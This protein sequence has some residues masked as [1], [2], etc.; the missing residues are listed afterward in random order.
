MHKQ[1]KAT[2]LV[3]VK[4]EE[5]KK[6]LIKVQHTRNLQAAIQASLA[7]GSALEMSTPRMPE[8]FDPVPHFKEIDEGHGVWII[9]HQSQNTQ[10]HK[11]G[12][13]AQTKY[14]ALLQAAA[15]LAE[16]QSSNKVVGQEETKF[17]EVPKDVDTEA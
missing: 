9:L 1:S 2:V 10:Q 14:L 15:A 8:V 3:L 13:E 5:E 12:M 11:D 17:P 6:T 16:Q 7:E 4:L